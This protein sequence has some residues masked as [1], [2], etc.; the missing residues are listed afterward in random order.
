MKS[1]LQGKPTKIISWTA[2]GVLTITAL[3]GCNL[4]QTAA[5]PAPAPVVPK[6]DVS[7]IIST[8]N[9]LFDI[10]SPNAQGDMVVL[11]GTAMSRGIY[12]IH[13]SDGSQSNSQSVSNAADAL[14]E[15]NSG[16]LLMGQGTTTSGAVSIVN[17][18]T[19]GV[20]STIAV[21]GPV[22]SMTVGP[23]PNI[24]Y[25]LTGNHK[26]SAVYV[27]N[28]KEKKVTGSIPMS[29]G[30]LEIAI[31]GQT[32]YGLQAN[33]DVQGISLQT[34]KPEFQFPAVKNP[35]AF[36]LSPDGQTLY[37]LKRTSTGEN[38]SVIDLATES[39]IKAIAAPRGANSMEINADGTLLYVG[40]STGKSSNVQALKTS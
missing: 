32:L 40:V 7:G 26:A 2:A 5:A 1:W 37:V 23:S 25:V 28:V 13:L 22:I 12:N 9:P 8:P 15:T 6:S 3:T 39:Q 11:A 18:A 33:G 38:V 20:S 36:V 16:V 35:V 19:L 21:G 10:T 34:K 31:D 27:L 29:L 14:T 17:A 24:V 30:T 4:L